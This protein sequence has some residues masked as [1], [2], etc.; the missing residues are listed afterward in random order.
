MVVVSDVKGAGA[1]AGA[2]TEHAI[3]IEG[4][5][6]VITVNMTVDFAQGHQANNDDIIRGLDHRAETDGEMTISSPGRA[7]TS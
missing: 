6:G 2:K 5:E 3:P 4:E 1:G 7:V